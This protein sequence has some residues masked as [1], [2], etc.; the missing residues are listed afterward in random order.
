MDDLRQDYFDPGKMVEF[1]NKKKYF[2]NL[3]TVLIYDLTFGHISRV[4]MCGG[5]VQNGRAEICFKV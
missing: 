1:R 3:L 5:M 4:S 2:K